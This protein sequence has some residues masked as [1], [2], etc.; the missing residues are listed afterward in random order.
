M[1]FF[2]FFYYSSKIIFYKT[3]FINC[4][5]KKSFI[6]TFEFAI[7]FERPNALVKRCY[8]A[9]G[10]ISYHCDPEKLKTLEMENMSK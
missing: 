9:L 6:K 5:G 2:S 1:H 7:P 4:C 3:I 10:D 8:V